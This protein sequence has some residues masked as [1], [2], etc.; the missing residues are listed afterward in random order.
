MIGARSAGVRE[1]G[2]RERERERERHER[3][4]RAAVAPDPGEE[5]RREP[6]PDQRRDDDEPDRDHGDFHDA[7][8][9]D[10]SLGHDARD[11]REDDEAQHVVGDGGAEHRPRL[12]RSRARA[13]RRTRAR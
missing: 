10:A 3:A 7:E 1:L 12:D 6:E 8:R 13:G 4:R 2:E 5:R 9:G 11:H